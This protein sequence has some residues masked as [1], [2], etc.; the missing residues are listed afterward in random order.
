MSSFPSLFRSD[1]GNVVHA[2]SSAAVHSY[3]WWPTGRVTV[4]SQALNTL[5]ELVQGPCPDNQMELVTHKFVEVV[6]SMVESGCG[7]GTLQ[8]KEL[9]VCG[10]VWCVYRSC[11]HSGGFSRYNPRVVHMPSYFSKS[12]CWP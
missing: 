4:T 11:G 10:R 5:T 6:G 1:T 9:Q 7:K 2:S 3:A 12:A 8:G